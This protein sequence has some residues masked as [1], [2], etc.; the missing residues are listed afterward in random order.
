MP[1]IG[2]GETPLL[3][4]ESDHWSDPGLVPAS[5]LVGKGHV[6]TGTPKLALVDNRVYRMREAPGTDHWG[7]KSQAAGWDGIWMG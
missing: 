2:S 5:D 4:V 6:V 7:E 1:S 3:G